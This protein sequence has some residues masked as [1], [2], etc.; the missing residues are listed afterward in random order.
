MK[1][2]FLLFIGFL[3]II[4]YFSCSDSPYPE[5]YYEVDLTDW[6]QGNVVGDTGDEVTC[7]IE[8]ENKT[9]ST[10]YGYVEVEVTTYDGRKYSDELEF[11]D[12]RGN[13]IF[14]DDLD[15]DVD[16]KRAVKVK[17]TDE[18]FYYR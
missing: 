8:V 6:R 17:I 10:I 15:I 18:A 14:E 9:I 2:K 4:V 5:S 1:S 11:P 7:Y 3:I 13:M 16:D 12:I